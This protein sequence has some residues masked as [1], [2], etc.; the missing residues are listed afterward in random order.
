MYEWICDGCVPGR[1]G[2]PDGKPCVVES[3]H[4]PDFCY[5]YPKSGQSWNMRMGHRWRDIHGDDGGVKR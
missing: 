3:E 2:S 5:F 1:C 4:S